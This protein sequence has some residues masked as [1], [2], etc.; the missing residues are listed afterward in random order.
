MS[1]F[2]TAPDYASALRPSPRI[3]PVVL[4]SL[5]AIAIVINAPLLLCTFAVL[6]LDR[7]M[8]VSSVLSD[9]GRSSGGTWLATWVTVDAVVILLATI[10]SG[11]T[12]LL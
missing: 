6:P 8:S 1:R 4:R 7:I 2:E 9:L 12:S 3:Y 5:Q 11:E 10:L